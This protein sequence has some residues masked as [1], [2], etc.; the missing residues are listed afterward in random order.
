LP[1]TPDRRTNPSLFPLLAYRLLSQFGWSVY[2]L[3]D[4]ILISQFI[5]YKYILK[6]G[7]PSTASS[8]EGGDSSGP[9]TPPSPMIVV[10]MAGY[11]V[12]VDLPTP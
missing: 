9:P 3:L 5:T 12:A 10:G 2:A 6:T 1:P 4:A 7:Q 11:V 8:Q